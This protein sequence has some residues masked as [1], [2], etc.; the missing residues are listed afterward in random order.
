MTSWLFKQD[1]VET[2]IKILIM[3]FWDKLDKALEMK[4][5]RTI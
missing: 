4:I 3:T 5:I 1:L 2:K